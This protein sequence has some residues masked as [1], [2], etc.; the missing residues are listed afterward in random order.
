MS[1]EIMIVLAMLSI[2]KNMI[3][4]LD[5]VSLISTFVA[6]NVRQVVFK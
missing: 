5:Y 2:E 3:E 6:K 4:K 1:Q